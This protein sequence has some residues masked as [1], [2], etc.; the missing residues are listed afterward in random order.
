MKASG[1]QHHV[2]LSDKWKIHVIDGRSA[3]RHLKLP[4]VV[5]DHQGVYT[6]E[7]RTHRVTYVT[8]TDVIVTSGN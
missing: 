7:V 1:L 6:C 3:W 8:Q 4:N 5:P 2:T